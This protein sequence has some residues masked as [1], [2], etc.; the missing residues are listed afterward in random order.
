MGRAVVNK[1]LHGATV[2]LREAG[3]RGPDEAEA[4][5]SVVARLF[6]LEAAPADAPE[7]PRK[8]GA[9]GGHEPAEKS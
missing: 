1:L 7:A 5:A 4:L 2:Q 6:D 8:N 9:T 3:E